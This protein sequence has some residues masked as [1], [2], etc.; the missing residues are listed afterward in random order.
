MSCHLLSLVRLTILVMTNAIIHIFI[1]QLS[2][3][4]TVKDATNTQISFYFFK[5]KIK[6]LVRNVTS[7]CEIKNVISSIFGR[8]KPAALS[9][10]QLPNQ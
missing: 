6:G 4:A 3:N 2:Y 7:A 1:S 5:K 8:L 10:Y 9:Y